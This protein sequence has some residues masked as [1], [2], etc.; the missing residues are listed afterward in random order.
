MVL[1]ISDDNS[2]RRTTPYVNYAL[3]AVNVLVFVGLQWLGQN[4]AFTYAFSCVPEEIVTGR[5]VVTPDEEVTDP[6]TKEVV[7]R[8]GLQPLPLGL[9]VYV[10]LLT[11]M[12]MH[13]GI[14]HLLGNMLFCGSA[15]TTSRTCWATD[16][17]WP[18]I[19][20][21]GGWRRSP[22]WRRRMRL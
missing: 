20:C 7:V 4:V 16:V 2:D 14:P 21:A 15:A 18:F 17:T 19:W 9:P 11:S 1:P 10:T 8:P 6:E 22:T 5:D 3:I 12:F 13:G